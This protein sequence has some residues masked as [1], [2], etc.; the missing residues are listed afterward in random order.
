[1][2]SDEGDPVTPLSVMARA[3]FF[4]TGTR[5]PIQGPALLGRKPAALL[6]DPTIIPRGE[7]G[8]V[9]GGGDRY[10]SRN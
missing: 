8:I 7:I 6:E 1:M 3:R 10:S 9:K 2:A 5:E 4:N